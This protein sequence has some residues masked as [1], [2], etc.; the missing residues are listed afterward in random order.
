M[1]DLNVSF[2]LLIHLEV[3]SCFVSCNVYH[4]A[5]QQKHTKDQYIFVWYNV[6]G[7]QSQDLTGEGHNILTNREG[8]WGQVYF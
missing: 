2:F 1:Q 4:G 8:T 5:L 6:F 7:I 3:A